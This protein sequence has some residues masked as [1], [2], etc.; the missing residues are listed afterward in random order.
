LQKCEGG[1]T[2]GI[3]RKKPK[4]LTEAESIAAGKRSAQLS[5]QKKLTKAT[6]AGDGSN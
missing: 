2:K 6:P 5:P 4:K 1:G 3:L